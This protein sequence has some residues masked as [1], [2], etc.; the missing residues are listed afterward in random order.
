METRE[1]S[2]RHVENWQIGLPSEMRAES[3]SH[4]E[5]S[6]AQAHRASVEAA[7]HD[8]LDDQLRVSRRD[9][10]LVA[11]LPLHIVAGEGHKHPREG[12]KHPEPR[13]AHRHAP[14]QLVDVDRVA[15]PVAPQLLALGVPAE[16][17]KR[18]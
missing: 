4:R 13:G 2:R 5:H 8:L 7:T 16:K 18:L 10:P 11:H 1:P 12:Y 17:K 9:E 6:E 3:R 15:V 14:L